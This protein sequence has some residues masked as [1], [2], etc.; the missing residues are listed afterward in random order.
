MGVGARDADGSGVLGSVAYHDDSHSPTR[1]KARRVSPR[2][3]GAD[4]E[5]FDNETIAVMAKPWVPLAT[6]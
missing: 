4:P 6:P 3:A 1:G 5:G 2:E